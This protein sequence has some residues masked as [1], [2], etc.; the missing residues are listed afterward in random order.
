MFKLT[1]PNGESVVTDKPNF[2]RVHKENCFIICTREKADGVAYKGNPCLFK[3][4]TMIHEVDISDIYMT[5]EEMAAAIRMGV[6]E[7]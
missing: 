2:I 5:I 4:G 3:D 1:F 6:N 7:I